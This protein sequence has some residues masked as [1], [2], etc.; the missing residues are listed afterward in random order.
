VTVA[1]SAAYW[2]ARYATGG[3]SG[4]GSYGRLATFKA[5]FINDFVERHQIGTIIDFGC[6]DG[7]LLSLLKVAGYTGVDISATSVARC[8]DRFPRHRFL[9]SDELAPEAIAELTLSIDVIFHLIEEQTYR[10]YLQALFAHASRYVV[11][12]ASNVEL[13]WPAPHVRHRRFTDRVL[14]A[15]PDWELQAHMPNPYPFNPANPDTTS[16][17]DFFVYARSTHAATRG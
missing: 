3:T 17:A 4:P 8:A 15:E 14:A 2:E 6:G 1:P 12:Y 11:I 7:N 13:G 10:R 5:A 9:H 16:F